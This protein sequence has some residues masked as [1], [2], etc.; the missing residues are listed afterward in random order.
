MDSAISLSRHLN[1]IVT[2]PVKK[3]DPYNVMESYKEMSIVT[4]TLWVS[5]KLVL[6][7]NLEGSLK[8]ELCPPHKMVVLSESA[9]QVLFEG[10]QPRTEKLS[11]AAGICIQRRVSVTLPEL[12]F[13]GCRKARWRSTESAPG[14]RLRFAWVLAI[15]CR[16][17]AEP[18][19]KNTFFFFLKKF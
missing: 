13:G 4:T 7:N 17:T 19:R 14:T 10:R 11:R 8:E 15:F 5:R 18:R 9:H 1:H 16:V 2:K 12:L 6:K 3:V